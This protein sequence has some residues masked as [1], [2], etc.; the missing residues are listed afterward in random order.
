MKTIT[1]I[2]VIKW[3]ENSYGDRRP[4][5]IDYINTEDLRQKKNKILNDFRSKPIDIDHLGGHN[6]GKIPFAVSFNS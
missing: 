5:T 6:L 4:I 2:L 1:L 3:H